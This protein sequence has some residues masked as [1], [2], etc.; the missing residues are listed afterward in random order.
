[1]VERS[2]TRSSKVIR[3]AA[4]V[5]SF[6]LTLSLSGLAW[7]RANA[8]PGPLPRDYGRDPQGLGEYE[9]S[10]TA[11]RFGP[12][13]KYINAIEEAEPWS[14]A[15]RGAYRADISLMSSSDP[16][17]YKTS[18]KAPG[19]ADLAGM[20]AAGTTLVL[21]VRNSTK[22][23]DLP[24]PDD[25]SKDGAFQTALEAMI[26]QLDPD[27]LVYGNEVNN[28]DK[29]SG[30]VAQFQHVMALGHAV[31][32]SK[33]VKDG[34]TALMGTVTSQ[35]TYADI[36]ATEGEEAASD[37]K[38]AA[39]MGPFEQGLADEANAYIDAC[40]AAGLDFFVWHSYFADDSVILSIKT[41]VEKRFGAASF[42][43]ELGWRTGK[44]STGIDIIDALSETEIPFVL[45][46]GSGEGQNEPDKLWDSSGD[47]TAEGETISDHLQGL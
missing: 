30:T 2:A 31:A 38:E 39:D 15:N 17:T 28:A 29:Y 21:T 16:I 6:G 22:K 32:S 23:I 43:N 14:P 42:I 34:G 36:L 13:G 37:F 18:F 46:Y 12:L 44:A 24:L 11:S 5:V 10:G 33:G 1:M 27:Y 8:A 41:Y 45:L 19:N 47:P 3:A 20:K 25:G 40:K 4:L 35:A 26:D 9:G 7:T